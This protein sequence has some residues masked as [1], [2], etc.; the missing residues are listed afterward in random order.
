MKY[1]RNI[2]EEAIL[3]GLWL[4]RLPSRRHGQIRWIN[5]KCWC[6]SGWNRA[7]GRLIESK[8]NAIEWLANWFN[9]ASVGNNA[10]R[11]HKQRLSCTE[12]VSAIVSF[13]YDFCLPTNF[14]CMTRC[15][16]L[17]EIR[18]WPVR[19]ALTLTPLHVRTPTRV[20]K[21]KN[22]RVRRLEEFSHVPFLLL[23]PLNYSMGRARV[24]HFC[25]HTRSSNIHVTC[26][27]TRMRLSGHTCSHVRIECSIAIRYCLLLYMVNTVCLEHMRARRTFF[28]CS[29]V[30]RCRPEKEGTSMN[31]WI[32][33]EFS[34]SKIIYLLSRKV[35]P[36]KHLMLGFDEIVVWDYCLINKYSQVNRIQLNRTDVAV[37][38]FF[39]LILNWTLQF[40]RTKMFDVKYILQCKGRW[41]EY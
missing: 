8:R 13:T 26:A 20:A 5:M 16:A 10:E 19:H 9:S 31:N 34:R 41:G 2:N 1:M 15:A 17:A 39:V 4:V 24:I 37:Y 11:V 28:Q 18:L 32:I 7:A 21:G 40:Q 6:C 14:I 35:V 29:S 23:L 33:I 30:H 36:C 22:L 12:K 3:W 38:T 27:Y 25:T